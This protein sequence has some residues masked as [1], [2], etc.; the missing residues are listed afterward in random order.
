MDYVNCPKAWGFFPNNINKG[1]VTIGISDGM[2]NTSGLDLAPT[3][4]SYLYQN[5]FNP[6][7]F[8]LSDSW[9]ATSVAA[10][11][12]AQ[13]NN[14]HGI[15]GVCYDCKIMNIP[16]G[17]DAFEPIDTPPDFSGLMEMAGLGVK[18][19]NMSWFMY[20]PMPSTPTIPNDRCGYCTDP[21]YQDG[22]IQSVQDAINQLHDMGVVLVAAAGNETSAWLPNDKYVYPASYNHVISVTTVHAKNHNLTDELTGPIPT[23][24]YISNYNE[25]VICANGGIGTDL[26]NPVFVPFIE[27]STT[28]NSRVDIC[29]PAFAPLYSSFLLGCPGLYGDTTSCATPFVTGTVALMQ[30]LNSCILPDEVEDVLQLTSKNL[31]IKPANVAFIGRSGSGKLETGDAVEFTNHMM[32]PIGDAVINNQ[33]FW[34]FNFDLQHINNKLTISNQIFRDSNTSNFIAK[35]VIEVLQ[36]SDFRPNA[37]GFVDLKIDGTLTVCPPPSSRNQ[38]S[39]IQGNHTNIINKAKLYPNPNN[40]TFSIMLSQ[41]EIKNLEVTVFDIIGKPVYQTIVNQNEFEL[42]VSHLPSGI[43]LVKLSSNSINETLKFVKK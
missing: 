8:C 1:N 12:S 35:N 15:T 39:G 11:A 6:S 43:Y 29:A 21:T 40:G 31:E 41:I 13:G 32:N 4:V 36:N 38:I 26:S 14:A 25:D 2:V 23:Y 7:F 27:W 33:D 10:I 34:R 19:I 24:G 22:F 16:Y 3:K 28:T 30:T 18:V 9:H 17:Y 5:Q 37:N 20:G 42:N